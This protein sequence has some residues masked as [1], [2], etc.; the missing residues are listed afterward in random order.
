MLEYNDNIGVDEAGRGPLLGSV[1][2][3]AVYINKIDDDIFEMVND[4]KKLSEKKRELIY[5]KLIS[6]DSIKYGI[7]LAS[8]KEIDE[9]NILNATF[10]AMNRALE[11]LNISDKLVVVDGNKLIKQYKGKQEY[12]VKG[13]S[14]NLSIALASIIAK[15]TRDKMMYEYDKIYKEYGIAS[16]KGYGTKKHYEAIEKYGILPIHRKTFLKK[17]LK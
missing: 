16:H 9:I 12:L 3:C 4:S 14:K 11:N 1:V 8:E 6:S 15:V 7:G 10:L 13:D 17:I 2:A 5:D